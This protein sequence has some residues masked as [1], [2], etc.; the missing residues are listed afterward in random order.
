MTVS[1]KRARTFFRVIFVLAGIA[2]W[3]VL[4]GIPLNQASANRLAQ[5]TQKQL[6]SGLNAERQAALEKIYAHFKAGEPFSEEEGKILRAFGG[7]AAV[8]DLEADVVISRALYD[9]YI[10]G[11]E[12]SPQQEELFDRYSLSVS[13]RVTDVADRK[14]Q[15]LNKR[16][17]AAATAEPRTSPLV[18]PPNDLCS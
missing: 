1:A 15:L 16:I 4:P 12:L 17:A 7:A 18:A 5:P 3:L 11:K 13:R 2:C 8:T 9:F 10:A 6:S 14:T